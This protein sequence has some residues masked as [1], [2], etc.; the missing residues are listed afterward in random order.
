MYAPRS[1]SAVMWGLST[2]LDYPPGAYAS[3]DSS[4]RSLPSTAASTTP[5]RAPRYARRGS[6]HRGRRHWR[7]AAGAARPS[8]SRTTAS[9]F[10]VWGAITINS[11]SSK[12]GAPRASM[13][14]STAT[15]TP[16]R[17]RP[18]RSC[19]RIGRWT[20]GLNGCCRHYGTPWTAP[21]SSA[22]CS[23]SLSSSSHA[24]QRAPPAISDRSGR[25]AIATVASDDPRA[26]T[27]R[28]APCR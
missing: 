18:P 2:G 6:W 24:A 23:A 11:D 14:R 19:C 10:R 9:R 27:P 4:H 17:A 13:S 15:R 3:T 26:S 1:R 20:A 25:M 12:M 7:S 5:T 28:R 16:T 22:R 21:T 8:T